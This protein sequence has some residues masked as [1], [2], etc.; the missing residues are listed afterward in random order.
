[1]TSEES[2]SLKRVLG[3]FDMMVLLL[4]KAFLPYHPKCEPHSSA[5]DLMVFQAGNLQAQ[6][7]KF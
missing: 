7:L 5:D 2:M 4:L 1:M 3:Y 6:A